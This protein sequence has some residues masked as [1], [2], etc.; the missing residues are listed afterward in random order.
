MQI[1]FNMTPFFMIHK[2]IKICRSVSIFAAILLI[3][4]HVITRF[5]QAKKKTIGRFQT[6]QKKDRSI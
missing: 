6:A 5:E 2:F 1:I 4:I 3:S